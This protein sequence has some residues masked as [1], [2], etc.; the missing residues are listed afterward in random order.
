VLEATAGVQASVVFDADSRAYVADMAGAVAAF[1]SRGVLLWRRVLDG[2]ISATPVVELDADR[3]FIGTHAGWLYALKSSDGAMLWKRQVPTTSDARIVADLLFERQSGRIVVS[4]W[5][6]QFHVIDPAT[7]ESAAT[8]NA[9]ISPQAAASADSKGRVYFLRSARDAG[10]SLVRAMPGGDEVVLHE[11]PAGARGANR[12]VV[13]ATPVVDEQRGILFFVSNGDRSGT[14][15]AWD[16]TGNKLVWSV[17]F[18]RAI[19]ASPCL[20]P[21]G[22]LMVADMSGALVAVDSGKVKFRYDTGS[23]YVL[24]GPVCGG[25]SQSYLGDPTGL[26]HC[27]SAEGSGRSFFEAQRSIQARPSWSP[28]GDLWV[29]AMDGHVYVFGASRKS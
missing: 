21:D 27:V 16:L 11:Q 10:V 18:E 9:G 5:G 13:L 26:L 24:A 1:D 4:S 8:W 23:D 14:V 7:G 20:R 15:H 6:G 22:V 25:T 29:P 12:L 3:L 19:V 28:D 17:D 2:A